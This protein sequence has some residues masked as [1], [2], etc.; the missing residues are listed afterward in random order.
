[1]DTG[2]SAALGKIETARYLDRKRGGKDRIF[3]KK[4]HLDLHLL[5]EE[6]RD[7][8]VVPSLFVIAARTVIADV[9][10]VVLDLVTEDIVE[11]AA[12]GFDL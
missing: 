11:H 9:D 5:A 7:V 1:L 4:I 12:F 2:L 10:D 8:N 6:T 3:A